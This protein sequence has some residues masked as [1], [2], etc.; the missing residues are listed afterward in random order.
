MRR[1]IRGRGGERKKKTTKTPA[2]LRLF[3]IGLVQCLSC[4]INS[5][6][7][8]LFFFVCTNS[9]FMIRCNMYVYHSSCADM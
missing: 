5:N 8:I 7:F 3:S 1:L 9:I 4:A 6:A 2:P